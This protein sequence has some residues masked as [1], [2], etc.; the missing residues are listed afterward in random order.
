M[1]VYILL[2]IWVLICSRIENAK[3]FWGNKKIL[4]GKLLY[5]LLT[6]I[7]LWFV[8]AF[9]APTVG[10]DTYANASY[11]V[12]AA[13]ASSFNYLVHDGIWKAGIG[14]ISY[15]LGIIYPGMEMYIFWSSTVIIIGFA[16]F[17][18]RTSNKVW[19]STF[20]FLTLNIYFIS[21]N[22]SRQFIAIAIIINAFWYIYHDNTSVIGWSLVILA[23]WIHNS[24]FSFLPAFLGMLLVKHCRNYTKLYV[25]SFLAAVI[26]SIGMMGLADIFASLFPHY[27]IYTQGT[28]GDNFLEN[29]GGGKIII[30]YISFLIVLIM[31]Y[32]IS[33]ASGKHINYTLMDTFLPGAIF[34][35]VV[36]IIYSTNTMM[37]RVTL[38]YQCLFI[39]LIPY[40]FSKFQPCSRYVI[41]MVMILGLSGYYFLWMSG[42][43]GNVVPYLLWL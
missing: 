41:Y 7:P 2:L 29:T 36:G 20:L 38:P 10:T 3:V 35:V 33:K 13:T 24:V 40:V 15:L 4:S 34:C 9:R 22:A 18:Y 5:L 27:A 1:A 19:L 32:V 42:N 11:F 25:V 17:I 28:I 23:A 39:S 14:V 8:M 21:L 30:T 43:L 37:N 12:S 26:F 16:V 6:F 31:Y